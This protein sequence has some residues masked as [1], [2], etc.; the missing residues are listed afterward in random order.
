MFDETSPTHRLLV[1]ANETCPCPALHELIKERAREGASHV[2]IVAPALNRRLRHFVSDVDEAVMHA[3]ERLAAV[4]DALLAAGIDARGEVGDARP[5]QALD[6][7]LAQ[8]EVHEVIVST[9]PPG[10]SHWLEKG[11][12]DY[13]TRRFDGPLT[14]FASAYGAPTEPVGAGEPAAVARS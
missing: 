4:V 3:Q 8:H 14:H 12:L 7:A 9:H 6:D 1:L 11:L 2:V 5:A 13:A 10:H